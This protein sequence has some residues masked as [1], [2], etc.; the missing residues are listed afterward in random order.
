MV[1]EVLS[2]AG[3]VVIVGHLEAQ[4]IT[5]GCRQHGSHVETI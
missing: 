2:L 5:C 4:P 1:E 3:Y